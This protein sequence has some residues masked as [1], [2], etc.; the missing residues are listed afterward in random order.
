[1]LYARVWQRAQ[2]ELA[3]QHAFGVIVL[4]VLR[5]SRD[6]RIQVGSLVVLADQFVSGSVHTLVRCG[7]FIT[8]V[9][10]GSPSSCSPHLA[11]LRSGSCRSPGSGTD[12][13]TGPA[14]VRSAWDWD[15]SSGMPPPP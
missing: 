9:R 15:S 7:R 14:P 5:L 6:F 3:E 11:S 2:Q 8:I 13:P 12:C 1:M 10:H 4:G